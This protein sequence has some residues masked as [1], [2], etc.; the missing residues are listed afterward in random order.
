LSAE[1]H[2]PLPAVQDLVWKLITAPEGVEKGIAD[3]ARKGDPAAENVEKWIV[4]D[5]RL[6]AVGRLDIYANMYFYRLK[7]A[8]LEDFPLTARVLGE[9]HFHNLVTDFLL[10]HPSAHYSLR[11]LGQP[12][13]SFLAGH[14]LGA[15]F[16]YLADV[17]ALEWARGEAFQAENGPQLDRSTLASLP[18]EKWAEIRF[19]PVAGVQVVRA[20]WDI[21]AL[22]EPLE[23]GGAPGDPA[24]KQQTLLVYREDN[25]A[26]HEVVPEADVKAVVALAEGQSFAKVCELVAADDDLQAASTRASKILAAW[27]KQGLLSGYRFE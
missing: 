13:P 20:Q 12:F 11:Y 27:L 3:L 7:D 9:T 23:S 15:Q 5:D 18:P 16:P 2:P 21:D 26:C 25:Q 8:L 6:S 24:A 1:S 22:W 19:I 14:E 10:K 4:S 17:A